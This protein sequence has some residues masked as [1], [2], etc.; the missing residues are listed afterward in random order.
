MKENNQP[1][2]FRVFIFSTTESRNIYSFLSSATKPSGHLFANFISK[3]LISFFA[4]F[5]VAFK[6]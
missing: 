6:H 5:Y 1:K 4:D 3:Q 2:L